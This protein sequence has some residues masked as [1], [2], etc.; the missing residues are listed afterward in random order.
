MNRKAVLIAGSLI[1][2][3]LLTFFGGLKLGHNDL[4]QDLVFGNN[5]NEIFVKVDFNGKSVF[6]KRYR[7]TDTI[8]IVSSNQLLN[9][10]SLDNVEGIKKF[11]WQDDQLTLVKINTAQWENIIT[12]ILETV[13]P[14][15]SS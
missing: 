4:Y 14:Q 3:L 7:D 9:S 15:K 11:N 10:A 13:I 12:S 2:A 8:S 5:S 6:I 1:L